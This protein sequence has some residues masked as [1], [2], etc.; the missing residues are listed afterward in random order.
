[1][2]KVSNTHTPHLHGCGSPVLVPLYCYKE[3]GFVLKMPCADLLQMVA[4]SLVEKHRSESADVVAA[5]QSFPVPLK[6]M[7]RWEN[8]NCV[9]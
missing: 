5:R 1:M 4:V 9:D 2:R 8:R 6:L 3:N 7:Q